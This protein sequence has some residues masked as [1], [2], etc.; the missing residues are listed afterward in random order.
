LPT[1]L[2]LFWNLRTSRYGRQIL[3]GLVSPSSSISSAI[4]VCT[5]ARAKGK[6]PLVRWETVFMR[7]IYKRLEILGKREE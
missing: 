2:P 4:G 6:S 5:I 7:A 1:L 3:D